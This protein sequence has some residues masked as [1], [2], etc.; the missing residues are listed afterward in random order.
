MSLD[1]LAGRFLGVTMDK[2]WRIRC[3][4]WE[5]ERLAQRQI[6]YAM[7]DALVASHMFLRLVQ[8]KQGER[9]KPSS[10]G[11]ERTVENTHGCIENLTLKDQ[12]VDVGN[13]SNQTMRFDDSDINR[14]ELEHFIK[15]D[16]TDSNILK[17]VSEFESAPSLGCQ[18]LTETFSNS[19]SSDQQIENTGS[20]MLKDSA[21][22]VVRNCPQS[23]S[24]SEQSESVGFE[25]KLLQNLGNF[26]T[27]YIDDGEEGI[28]ELTADLSKWE[29]VG[30]TSQGYL[31]F[32]EVTNVLTDSAF[33]QR[34]V[35]LCQ[36]IVDLPFK[37]TKVK[38]S[39]QNHGSKETHAG[40]TGKP[41]GKPYKAGTIRKS[42]LYMNCMLA[43]PDGTMLCTL[44]RKK[45]DWYVEKGIGMYSH[46]H[47]D[48]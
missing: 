28:D 8:L 17:S 33:Y 20:S 26:S 44:D 15:D 24:E 25:S 10:L 36:G 47:G 22:A 34:A 27:N 4:N 32:T 42:P 37:Q 23:C 29:S 7:N 30:N 2:S 38:D 21:S 40:I 45:A 5:A 6:E 11:N 16:S 43:A 31:D 46:L 18:R 14:K 48:G 41:S 39:G 35:S 9:K 13:Q 3:S 1:A 19:V 12:D